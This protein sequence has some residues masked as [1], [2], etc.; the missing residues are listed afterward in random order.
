MHSVGY[1]S[2]R[3]SFSTPHHERDD[4][5]SQQ[6]K[7]L[8]KLAKKKL[9][10]SGQIILVSRENT[11]KSNICS[12]DFGQVDDLVANNSPVLKI[13]RQNLEF[14]TNRTSSI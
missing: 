5:G 9:K 2:T 6:A 11:V 13:Y 12:P 7:I 8:A 1:I 4:Q 3:F 10:K 14:L